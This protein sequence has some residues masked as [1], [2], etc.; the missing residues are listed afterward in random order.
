MNIDQL[1]AL[2]R[3]VTIRELTNHTG[4]CTDVDYQADRGSARASLY[5]AAHA[6]LE[7]NEAPA[8]RGALIDLYQRVEISGLLYS[9]ALEA[10]WLSTEQIKSEDGSLDPALN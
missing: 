2:A 1:S 3:E 9:I 10:G 4:W 8:I 5:R 6:Y 7:E